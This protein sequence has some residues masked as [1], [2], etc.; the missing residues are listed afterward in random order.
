MKYILYKTLGTLII[1]FVA[2]WSLL[3]RRAERDLIKADLERWC[4]WQSIPY[5]LLS[6]CA[7]FV[8]LPEFRSVLYRRIGIKKLPWSLLFRGQTNLTLAC[9]D[10]GPGLIVQHG[11]S[12]VVVAARV[13][14][15]FHVN[16][17]VNIVW[18]GDK[19][20][21]IGDNVSV[22]AGAIIVGGVTI[23]DNVTIGAGAVVLKD[24]PSD[25]IVVGNPAKII[26]KNPQHVHT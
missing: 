18:N 24:V 9:S 19:R 25:C 23:G 13:G 4:R 16:Q 26:K 2:L 8:W 3:L 22:C 5:N 14:R 21:V 17:C 15:N 1:P 7:L 11:W 10:I 6:F 20:A 12:T